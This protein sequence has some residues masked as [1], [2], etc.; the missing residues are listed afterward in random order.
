MFLFCIRCLNTSILL[1]HQK[2]STILPMRWLWRKLSIMSYFPPWLNYV[3]R[4]ITWLRKMQ[5]FL[6]YLAPMVRYSNYINSVFHVCFGTY[7]LL[8]R[9]I[10]RSVESSEY[11]EV[12]P[13]HYDILR[14]QLGNMPSIAFIIHVGI[15]VPI[16]RLSRFCGLL[17]LS[18]V[19]V[20]HFNRNLISSGPKLA[21]WTHPMYTNRIAMISIYITSAFHI[22]LQT[23]MAI[24]LESNLGDI[25]GVKCEILLSI[26]KILFI[27]FKYGIL[28]RSVYCVSPTL[29]E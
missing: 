24:Y 6:C 4:Y 10:A 22:W 19:P 26:F 23:I 7:F 25:T 2:I 21:F 3:K 12:Y 17:Q 28:S 27:S 13:W 8:L 1:A 16:C 5:V 20:V 9:T 18:E 15:S 11:V 29:V 14:E